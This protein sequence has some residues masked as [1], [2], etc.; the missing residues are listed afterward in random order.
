MVQDVAKGIVSL[1]AALKIYGVVITDGQADN[2]ATAQERDRICHSRVGEFIAD[3][4]KFTQGEHVGKLND[5][6]F[7]IRDNRGI[8]V[9]TPAG[10][11]LCTGTSSWRA[12]A[13][14]VTSKELSDEYHIK[15]HDDLVM[16]TYYCP[17]SGMMLSADIHERD[18]KPWDDMT[19]HLESLL[20]TLSECA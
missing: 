8:H 18:Q 16:T 2:E 12:G 4:A 3:K 9:T 13:V 1:E 6:L 20:E 14:A 5:S 11:I 7:L 17:A 15:L 19:V 10:Y